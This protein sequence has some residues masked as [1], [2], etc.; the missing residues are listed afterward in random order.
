MLFKCNCN[1]GFLNELYPWCGTAT[2]GGASGEPKPKCE[3]RI[4]YIQ[5]YQS[6]KTHYY[7]YDSSGGILKFDWE[8]VLE[9]KQQL[10]RHLSN[11]M[12]MAKDMGMISNPARM[13]HRILLA[14]LKE[15]ISTIEKRM[16]EFLEESKA[17]F[18]I[19][20]KLIE[21]YRYS[22]LRVCGL[23]RETVK[24]WGLSRSES[25]LT[26]AYCCQILKTQFSGLFTDQVSRM[27]NLAAGVN[28]NNYKTTDMIDF[29]KRRMDDIGE[30]QR[31]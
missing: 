9:G 30:L 26:S 11:M 6:E 14:D 19:P 10:K 21:L 2:I 7:T 16:P 23:F 28:R 24:N 20:S 27:F 12:N 4:K 5:C 31:G 18:A 13:E 8:T 1:Q 15:G 3:S 22:N 17:C 29:K 25:H